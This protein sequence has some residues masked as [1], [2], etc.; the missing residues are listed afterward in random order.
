MKYED[1][2][3]QLKSGDLAF[4]SGKTFIKKVI[5][6]KT[7]SKWDHVGVIHVEHGRVFLMHS[8][9]GKGPHMVFLSKHVPDEIISTNAIVTEASID[10]AYEQFD[11]KYSIID[12]IRAGFGLRENA[13]GMMCSEFAA[14]FLRAC[15][16]LINEWGA[17]PAA[18]YDRFIQ[19]G[20]LV[21]ESVRTA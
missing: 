20:S 3:F 18:L 15:G 4:Y 7:K 14:G 10:W 9:P 1:V 21:I 16:M 13:K 19:N 5:Q 2:R 17:T 8:R 6:W 12:A 11:F